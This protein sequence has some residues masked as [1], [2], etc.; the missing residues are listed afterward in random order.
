MSVIQAVVAQ[1][2]MNDK[3]RTIILF[4]PARELYYGIAHTSRL[5]KMPITDFN[6]A[7]ALAE[8]DAWMSAAGPED[9]TYYGMFKSVDQYDAWRGELYDENCEA[10]WEFTVLRKDGSITS[11]VSDTSHPFPKLFQDIRV[12]AER[13]GGITK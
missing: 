5:R 2:Q 9:V 13:V 1:D 3:I 11:Y 10:S 7:A 6:F 4:F 12:V 8:L